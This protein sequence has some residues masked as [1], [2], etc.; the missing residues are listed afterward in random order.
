LPARDVKRFGHLF[1]IVAR[2][3]AGQRRHRGIVIM[4]VV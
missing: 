2:R 3:D 1:M 4:C